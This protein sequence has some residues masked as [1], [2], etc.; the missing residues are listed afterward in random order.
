VNESA[1]KDKQ[2]ILFLLT[3]ILGI[4]TMQVGKVPCD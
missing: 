2:N 3:A 4:R 1:Q